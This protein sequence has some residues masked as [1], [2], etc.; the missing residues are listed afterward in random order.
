MNAYSEGFGFAVP[1]PDFTKGPR[2]PNYTPQELHAGRLLLLNSHTKHHQ[3]QSI[4]VFCEATGRWSKP[5]LYL[6]EQGVRITN[7]KL[8]NRAISPF[9]RRMWA[10]VTDY[11]GNV[12]NEDAITEDRSREGFP[13]TY[14]EAALIRTWRHTTRKT[15]APLDMLAMICGRS[16][17]VE[18]ER[19][20]PPTFYENPNMYDPTRKARKA[21]ITAVQEVAGSSLADEAAA[22]KALEAYRHLYAVCLGQE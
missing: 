8:I 13:I 18:I 20:E 5:I 17:T 3:A 16:S 1:V 9:L 19:C 10:C 15:R 12:C 6:K 2:S 21:L 14:G 22:K 7:S 4:L 11:P